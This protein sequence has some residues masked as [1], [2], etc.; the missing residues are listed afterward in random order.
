[1]DRSSRQKINKETEALND[2]LDQMD[3]TDIYRAFNPKEIEYA[4]FSCANG[5]F[6]R[7]DHML[8]HKASLSKF[9]NIEIISSFFSNHNAM[10]LESNYKKKTLKNHKY[11]EAKQCVTK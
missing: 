11:M 5:T 6:S 3:L 7:T 10:G 2:T 4:F 8:G 9:K 1:M